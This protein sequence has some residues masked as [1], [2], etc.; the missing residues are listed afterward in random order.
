MN[1]ERREGLIPGRTGG[2]MCPAD[3]GVSRL[4][5]SPVWPTG[6][7]AAWL[8]GCRAYTG[9]SAFGPL[10]PHHAR[11]SPPSLPCTPPASR[12]AV[13]LT[14]ALRVGMGEG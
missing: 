13:G 4:A 8:A 10:D 1:G 6:C 12:P 9:W 5:A 3:I 14:R 11:A 2:F 7:L